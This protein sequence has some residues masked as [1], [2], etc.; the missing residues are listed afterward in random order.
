[1]NAM[2]F[3]HLFLSLSICICTGTVLSQDSLTATDIRH[4]ARLFDITFTQNE[5]DSLLPD[6]EEYRSDYTQNRTLELDNS[7]GPAFY[8][9]P[10]PA[11]YNVP[12]GRSV[13]RYTQRR[14][15]IPT[16]GSDL[17]F[18]SIADLAYLIR[19][20]LMTSE[21][22]TEF[23]IG[24]LEEYDSVLHCVIT[25]TRE[26]ALERAR[27]MDAE[28]A[29]GKYRGML[30]GIP[31]G[32]KDLFAV[33][34]YKTTWGAM[35]F[36]DQEF[37]VDAT[38]VENLDTA[39]AVL[40][41]KLT[42]GALAWGDVWYGGQT[43]NPWDTT[44]GSSG[45]SAGSAA[46]VAAGLVPFAIGTETLGSIVSPSTVCGTTGLRPTFGRVSRYGAM[47]LSW[48][49]DK[50]GP[51]CRSAQDCAIV[52]EAIRGSDLKDHSTIDAP[53]SFD[54]DL[55]FAGLKVGYVKEAF[56]GD[57]AF[58]DQDS[59]ALDVIRDLGI[60]LTEVELP[61]YPDITF[62]LTVEAAAAFDALTRSGDDD[63]LVRQIRNAWP[64]VFRSARFV[65]AVE[66]I[67][68]NRL[69]SIL[70]EDMADL[71]EQVDVIV[72][73]SWASPALTITNMTG[74]PTVVMPNGFHEDRPTSIS[75]TGRLF[76]E[77]DLLRLAQAFQDA[78]DWDEKKPP[79]FGE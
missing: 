54:P 64:N 27:K 56:E 31:Y 78:T 29:Q 73:P 55:S 76:H 25:I 2:L 5:I 79:G 40:I 16:A 74:H 53:F 47:A 30:H 42:L 61:P 22:M 39:G 52:F 65:P 72:H 36:K 21:E 34:G 20:G 75:V 7:T 38:V 70:I 1:M 10:F 11:G 62:I 71:F 46:A 41:A 37:D 14:L 44:L 68:A 66:Y 45:S 23:F 24:R 17:A 58:R 63:L 26:R 50:I 51:I 43:R 49:M 57:Y 28:I 67:Q 9:K 69:R 12:K 59:V 19:N 8:F 3:R 6:L 35:P 15:R 13:L 18:Y 33:K 4:A 60:E 48:S 32:I 77:G